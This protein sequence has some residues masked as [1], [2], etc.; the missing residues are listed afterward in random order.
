MQKPFI[1]EKVT[2]H[3]ESLFIG[4]AQPRDKSIILSFASY[5]NICDVAVVSG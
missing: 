1:S 5:K 4:R 3:F 2:K